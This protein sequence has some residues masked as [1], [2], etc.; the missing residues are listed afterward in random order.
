M[1][2]NRTACGT[3]TSSNDGLAEKIR[4]CLDVDASGGDPLPFSNLE[5]DVAS[6]ELREA[7][8]S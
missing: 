7:V 1:W 3:M 5:H 2:G 4:R 8:R 6:G